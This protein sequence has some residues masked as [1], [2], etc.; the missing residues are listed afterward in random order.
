MM[1]YW[2]MISGETWKEM[3]ET[4]RTGILAQRD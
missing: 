4:G 3:K 1:I 2:V